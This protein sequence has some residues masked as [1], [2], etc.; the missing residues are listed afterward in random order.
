METKYNPQ[1]IEQP[2]YEHWEKQGYFKPHGD[3]SKESFS[4]MIPPPNVTGSLH[5]GHAF[6]QTIMDTLIRYQRM[7]GKNTLWQAGTDHA[8]IATQMVVE[9]KIAAE[10]GKTR[11]DYGRE[12]FIDKIWQW[13]GESGGNITNQM[14]RLGNSVDWE[15]E[16]FTMDEGLSNAVK[17]VFVRLY[18]EDL[19][20]RGKRLVNWDPK[21]RTA[22]SDLEVENREVKGSMWH[23]RYPLA[24]GVKT[25]EGKDYLVVAT[26]RPETVLGD[27]G[28]AV[29]PE[30]PRYKDLIGKEVILPLIGRRIPIVGDEHA[31]MEKGTGCVKITPAHDFNDYEVGKRHQLPMVNILTFD[32]DIRQ[33]AE[34]FDTNGEAS[35]ACSS[36]IPAAF[37]GLERFAARKALVAAFDELG[38]LEEIK[39]HDL[40][41]PYGDRGGVVIE[42][43][44]TDQWYVRAAVLAKPAVEAVEDGRIQFVPK[45]YEN[46][47]FSWMRDIQDW[48]I[49]RQLWWGHRIPAWYD[50]NGNVYVGRTEAE[51]RSENNLADDVV[52]NQDEDV[53]DTWFSSGLWTFS[54]LGWPE[55]TP[56]LKAFHPSSVMVSGFDIIFFWIARMIM[57][58]MHFIKDEDGKPQ[59]PFHT[60]YMTGLIRD[61]EGQKMSKS[62]GN[63]IDP[64]DMVDGISLE[65]LLEKRTG[66][67]MQPQLAEKIR[68]RTEKQFPNGIEPHGTDA[69]RFT[70]AALASTGRDINWDMKRLEG[71]RNFCNKL[72]N[73]SR[74]VLM[75][76]EDQ[77][78]GF[79]A[80]EKVLSLADRWVLAEFN[81]TVKAYREALDGYRFDIAANILYEFTWNQFCD[82]YLELTKPV[83]NGGSE[84]ELRGTRHTLVTVLEALLRLAHPIIPFITET[85][86]LRVKALKG[87][88]ADTIML[89]PFPEFDA[90]QEDTLALNDLE[91]IK[92]AIIAVRNIRAEMNIAPGKPLEVLLRDVTA[93]AQ[94]R[95]EENRSFIQTLARLESITLL[96]AGD[97]GPVSVTKLIDGAELL[98]PM[99]GLID[100]AAELDR[101][102]KE[103]AK[104]EAEIERIESKLSNEGF[105]ARAPEAVVA[106]ER[107][108]LDGY[109]V[110]KA[111]LLEQHA[112][113]AAL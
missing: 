89:Q 2:L 71:Y 37:Q 108:K 34:V 106:K 56:D 6:Q 98:I 107:E 80:G 53:L 54:T 64:L 74:F 83:M 93:E 19:I 66:N 60:V 47:Y 61:D 112:V 21:L 43:M 13:K 65:A 58:T 10:E 7:Q 28:V 110:A 59:V 79:G 44:L 78:C 51:V 3:T 23:L 86:W 9:R 32:G 100:K 90:A 111:K 75:N 11:H 20:Y 29:N 94:R 77:D 103:V 68:K 12:A 15:R 99:A 55:Q 5:M 45:Q 8:G 109:A 63:V 85:I 36:D 50:A 97:K 104:I 39:A 88:S 69:L 18:K 84:A 101:L 96:P 70:L 40:T 95:V 102:T 91:W 81:R 57:L 30:D 52:L 49:S 92:Q 113:I 35:T 73:A 48:C 76:T 33:S 31:D 27:T 67:M 1:D 42:P 26:T 41:V 87:I 72:W 17:E 25:A 16:R 38:L 82:W 62:K 4:I 14:R 46:M 22:I 105:V 24:D